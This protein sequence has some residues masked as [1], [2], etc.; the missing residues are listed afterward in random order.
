MWVFGYGSL[1]IDRWERPFDGTP[2]PGAALAGYRR[3]FVKKSTVNWGTPES[4]CP[5]LGLLPDSAARCVGVA[6]ELAD[7]RRHAVR[8]YL[9]HREGP[10]FEL[11]ELPVTLLGGRSVP[12]LVA[13]NRLD[14]AAWCG[15]LSVEKR[16]AMVAAAVGTSGRCRDYVTK[17][18]RTLQKLRLADPH[19]AAFAAAVSELKFGR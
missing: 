8:D 17:V 2:H 15:D 10:T 13:I 11:R 6:F 19:V 12:A 4:P 1:M 14:T 7:G 5:T 18:R 3:G 16:A 9:R